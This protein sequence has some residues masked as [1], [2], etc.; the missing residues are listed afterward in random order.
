MPVRASHASYSESCQPRRNR[1]TNVAITAVTTPSSRLQRR[2]LSRC[3][4]NVKSKQRHTKSTTCSTLI[5]FVA[6]Y[7]TFYHLTATTTLYPYHRIQITNCTRQRNT[8]QLVY[9]M[10]PLERRL[11]VR[12]KAKLKHQA[13]MPEPDLRI[14]LAHAC[15]IDAL[16]FWL[17]IFEQRQQQTLSCTSSILHKP[18]GAHI[19]WA[20]QV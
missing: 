7:R 20:D 13:A 1:T 6:T 8:A 2:P 16:T 3:G 19:Q 14:S 11:L 15:L 18:A 5:M 9:K 12:A 10:V 4:V 17:S